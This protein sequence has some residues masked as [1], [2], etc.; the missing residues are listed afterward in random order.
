MESSKGITRRRFIGD[1][2]RAAVCL[3][4]LGGIESILAACTKQQVVDFHGV[5]STLVLEDEFT[6]MDTW[7]WEW[8]IDG[9]AYHSLTP[10]GVKLGVKATAD[11]KSYSNSEFYNHGLPYKYNFAQIRLKNDNLE[12]GTRGWGF[13]NG[14]MVRGPIKLAWFTQRQGP[15]D[16]E[17]NGFWAVTANEGK[18]KWTP[19]ENIPLEDWNTYSIDWGQDGVTWWINDMLVA[20]E[21]AIVPNGK[22]R[23]DIWI[24]NAVYQVINNINT[25]IYQNIIK[26][27]SLRVDNLKVLKLTKPYSPGTR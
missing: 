23:V 4:T 21:R 6:K 25:H 3:S 10:E 20:E 19:I 22:M 9:D 15:E 27:T 2:A 7:K 5:P 14:S 13:W 12:K 8:R 24:D 16:Y 26:E 17:R 11:D 1:S 18:S